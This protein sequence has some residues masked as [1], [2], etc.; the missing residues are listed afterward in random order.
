M[1]PEIEIERNAAVYCNDGPAVAVRQVVVDVARGDVTDL[2]LERPDGERLVIPMTAVA[3][4]DGRTV[5]L[6]LSRT[7]LFGSEAASL[8]Y[9][10]E[11]FYPLRQGS[12]SGTTRTVPPPHPP[13]GAQPPSPPPE[14]TASLP[15]A[16]TPPGVATRVV[17][18]TTDPAALRPFTAGTLRVPLSGE[19]LVGE[20]RAVV[21]GEIIVR[22][23]K[24]YRTVNVEG[25][26]RKEQIDLVDDG[27]H[28]RSAST[29]G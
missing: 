6:A 15:V 5:T 12:G 23:V 27:P 3:H 26:V 16:G 11:E 20:R 14:Q 17:S 9:Q 1:R 21:S 24:Q 10:P 18:A 19:Q 29:T 28:R 4:A 22:K 2:I 25:T 13:P 7:R 8:R